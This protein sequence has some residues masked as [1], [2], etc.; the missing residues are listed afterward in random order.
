MLTHHSVWI[1]GQGLQDID[2]AVF[3]VDVFEGTPR[4]HIETADNPNADGAR[5]LFR[6]R[7]EFEITVL[8]LIRDRDPS[9]R[10]EIMDDVLAW[11]VNGQLTTS[12]RPGTYANV[13]VTSYPSIDSNADW[14]RSLQITLTAYE[15]YWLSEDPQTETDTTVATVE[16]EITIIPAGTADACYLEFEIANGAVGTMDTISIDVNGYAFTFASLGLAVN[17]SLICGYDD[18]GWI[19][20]TIDGVSVMDKRSGDDDLILNQREVNTVAITTQRAATVTLNARG[21][22]K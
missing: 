17:K 9:R 8:F 21:R 2:D 12:A 22:W 20:F 7:R 15:G 4:L 3:V 6:Y 13:K 1:D 10:R 11:C 16:K 14:T 5:M 19:Y 18:N